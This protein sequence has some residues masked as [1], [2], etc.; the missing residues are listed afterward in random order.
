MIPAILALASANAPSRTPAPSSLPTSRLGQLV[1]LAWEESEAETTKEAEGAGAAP[2]GAE[3]RPREGEE[4]LEQ[5]EKE[6]KLEQHGRFT[7]CG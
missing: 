1:A 2:G 5:V 3:G 4:M 6:L 7:V